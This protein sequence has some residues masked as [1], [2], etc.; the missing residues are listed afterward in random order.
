MFEKSSRVILSVRPS[1]AC[2]FSKD[3]R[4]ALTRL[5]DDGFLKADI[6]PGNCCFG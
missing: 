3:N 2:P 1:L 6:M 4:F 5:A